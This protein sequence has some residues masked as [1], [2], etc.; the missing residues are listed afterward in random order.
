M[1]TKGVGWQMAGEASSCP[2]CVSCLPSCWAPRDRHQA[3]L[4][5]SFR[6]APL[7]MA[8]HPEPGLALQRA[9]LV[10]CSVAAAQ[11]RG[12]GLS[13]PALQAHGLWLSAVPS[14]QL[15]PG[16]HLL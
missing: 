13:S 15:E 2:S 7:E 10:W 5:S 12:W 9:G 14:A 1:A 3:L 8:P 4:L 16:S 6:G 11:S